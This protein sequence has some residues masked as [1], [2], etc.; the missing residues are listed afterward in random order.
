[1]GHVSY[2]IWPHQLTLQKSDLSLLE[3][4]EFYLKTGYRC[5]IGWVN[6]YRD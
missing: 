4:I 3:L 6:S 1:V 2:P 5:S